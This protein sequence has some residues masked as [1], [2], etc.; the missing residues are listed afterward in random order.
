MASRDSM[1]CLLNWCLIWKCKLLRFQGIATIVLQKQIKKWTYDGFVDLV[2]SLGRLY[3]G[4]VMNKDYDSLL[5]FAV[6]NTQ[7]KSEE[8][9]IFYS[10][11]SISVHGFLAWWLWASNESMVK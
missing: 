9:F 4:I 6:L 11:L 2:C 7:E 1:T 3:N 5:S 10:V 8:M